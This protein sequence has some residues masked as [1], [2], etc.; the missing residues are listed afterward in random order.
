LFPFHL[1]KILFF[2]ITEIAYETF[3]SPLAQVPFPHSFTHLHQRA[4]KILK[5][6]NDFTLEVVRNRRNNL[7]Q[8]S[9]EE[10]CTTDMILQTPI[11]GVFLN[12]EEA[13]F[14]VNSVIL[15][16]HDTM[17][18]SIT[19]LMY[20]LAKY[21]I[22][23][24]KV[25]QEV[26]AVVKDDHD[27]DI[28]EDELDQLPY[29]EAVIKESLR[30]FPPVPFVGRKLRLEKTIGD[31]VFPKDVEVLFALYLMMRNPKYFDDPL[32][33]N[34]DRFYG[35]NNTLNAFAAFS[36][37]ARKCIG[38]KYAMMFLKITAAKFLLKN[39]MKLTEGQ[40]ELTVCLDMVLKPKD[41][42]LITLEKR[43]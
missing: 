43:T 27:C 35:V 21:P 3:I 13:R 9:D 1:S 40:P 39:R 7:K 29:L 28:E 36:I 2:R 15:G 33:F 30:L 18:T 8:P 4:E 32:T 26:K 38:V 23:Q 41:K 19:F 24:E 22:V 25:Y 5:V 34:P 17:K 16:N 12:D 42:I 20:N 10:Y 14:E 31:Y 6:L 37:G 11:D